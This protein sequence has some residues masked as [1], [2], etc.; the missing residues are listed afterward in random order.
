[1]KKLLWILLFMALALPPAARAADADGAA[2]KNPAGNPVDQFTGVYW[3]KSTLE[4]KEAYLFG[5]D[6]AIAVEARIAEIAREKDKKAKNAAAFTLSPFEKGWMTA[7]K[8]LSRK[9]VVEE[10]D[11]WY[12]DNPGQLERPVMGVLWYEVVAPRL[13]AQ[14]PDK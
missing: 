13:K 1:M 14:T 12:A 9:Q 7:F 8:D 5:I 6:S 11:K 10:V 4:N 2:Y 3:Q